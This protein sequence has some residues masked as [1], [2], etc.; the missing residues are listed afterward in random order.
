MLR[1]LLGVALLGSMTAVQQAGAACI[2]AGPCKCLD[3]A[4]GKY[5]DL[6]GLA[7]KDGTYAFEA[8]QADG[9]AINY[10][11]YN[12]CLGF[13][14]NSS[15]CQDVTVCELNSETGAQYALGYQTGAE[16][17]NLPLDPTQ[18]SL[19]YHYASETATRTSYV[20][21]TCDP[22]ARVPVFNY[23]SEG[24]PGT[25]YFNLTTACAC[26][27]GCTEEPMRCDELLGGRNCSCAL[28]NSTGQ[29]QGLVDILTLNDPYNPLNVNNGNNNHIHFNPCSDME[30]VK[31]FP[32]QCNGMT[33]CY[34][35]GDHA[36]DYGR[37]YTGK[38]S[39][40]LQSDAVLTYTS[41]D[42]NRSTVI[43]LV[44]DPDQRHSPSL[45]L[46][47]PVTNEQ[48]SLELRSVCACPGECQQEQIT[49][50]PQSDDCTCKM[51]QDLGVFTLS[52]LNNPHAPLHAVG[53]DLINYYYN[54][55]TNITIPGPNGFC[56]GVAGCKIN[57]PSGTDYALGLQS[58]V[59]F[60]VSNYDPN[61]V[62]L[63]YSGGSQGKSFVIEAHCNREP[64]QLIF[65]F[66]RAVPSSHGENSIYYF[67][68]ESDHVCPR[69]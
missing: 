40:N 25:F 69:T 11:E 58:L 38:F 64:N 10:Y 51:S 67:Y 29:F 27:G 46:A 50:Q 60:R 26:P 1:L 37:S 21:L 52:D 13:S 9:Q 14:T 53:P 17:V 57:E 63:T 23:I 62:T 19:K 43:T 28:R 55:C 3:E 42:G 49:C 34:A 22:Q 61:I 2:V 36:I 68:L 30:H 16:F 48:I 6:T 59:S 44:C 66:I 31:F 8:T 4:T 45:I 20:A 47:G 18:L 65:K 41:E 39:G 35:Q 32:N 7:S 12:P 24:P 33:V 5:V 15:S 56:D 54:P